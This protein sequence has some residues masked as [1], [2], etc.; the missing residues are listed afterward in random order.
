M[1]GMTRDQHLEMT[2]KNMEKLSSISVNS[3][4]VSLQ[5]YLSRVS[6]ISNSSLMIWSP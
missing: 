2:S 4:K 1:T 6:D 5:N 3:E